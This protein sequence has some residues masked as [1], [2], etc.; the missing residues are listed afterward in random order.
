MKRLLAAMLLV[1]ASPVPC[2][3]AD[4]SEAA[5][6]AAATGFV[7]EAEAF[8]RDYANDLVTGDRA[9][10]VAR[11]DPAGAYLMGGGLKAF[12]RHPA[13]EARYA[14]DSWTR[15]ASFEWRDLSFDPVGPDAVL[16]A[17][18]FD[19]GWGDAPIE[20]WSYTAVLVRRGGT[21]R[22]RLEHEDPTLPP[23]DAAV[24]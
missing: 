6:T 4:T 22:I 2:V 15:P 17:G 1:A 23:A 3:A 20:T 18:L 13:I 21:L 9:A 10:I 7:V 11:Y 16:V 19:W 14:A 24:E 8:M 5:A 12:E